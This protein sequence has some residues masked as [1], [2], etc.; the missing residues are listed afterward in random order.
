MFCFFLGGGAHVFFWSDPTVLR[1]P[2]PPFVPCPNR[3]HVSAGSQNVMN[4][5]LNVTSDTGVDMLAA[6]AGVSNLGFISESVS[7]VAST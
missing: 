2:E 7:K 6:R 3:T 4:V 1:P 5:Q